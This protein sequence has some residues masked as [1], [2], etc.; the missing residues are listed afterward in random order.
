MLAKRGG[1]AVAGLTLPLARFDRRRVVKFLRIRKANF[2]FGNDA[3]LNSFGPPLF[4]YPAV[5]VATRARPR[6]CNLEGTRVRSQ[7]SSKQ[8]RTKGSAEALKIHKARKVAE[9]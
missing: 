7:A 1:F 5:A 8:A 6:K 4:A 3:D 9:N 2:S